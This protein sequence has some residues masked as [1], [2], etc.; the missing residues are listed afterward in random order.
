MH[1]RQS[2]LRALI[3]TESEVDVNRCSAFSPFVILFF[4]V[5]HLHVYHRYVVA[6]CHLSIPGLQ[7]GLMVVACYLDYRHQ[8]GLKSLNWFLTERTSFIYAFANYQ[9]SLNSNWSFS[10][11]MFKTMAQTFDITFSLNIWTH[12]VEHITLFLI[13]LDLDILVSKL[14]RI[15]L[16]VK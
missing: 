9:V 3:I 10:S 13:K 16:K 12:I 11:N 5:P 1:Y 7:C 8:S 2:Y 6:V 14:W 15:T 4:C